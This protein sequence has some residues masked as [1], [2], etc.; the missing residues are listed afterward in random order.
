MAA[1]ANALRRGRA[2]DAVRWLLASGDQ[3]WIAAA[4]N[5]LL[6]SHMRRDDGALDA[7]TS[8]ASQIDAVLSAIGDAYVFSGA[9]EFV[10]NYARL[11]VM[12]RERT[13]AAFAARSIELLS[14]GAA[15][16]RYWLTLM[17]DCVPLLERMC[18]FDLRFAVC[19]FLTFFLFFST[20][21]KLFTLMC[22]R[23][24]T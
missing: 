14:D 8:R 9:L 5:A 2:G 17:L 3:R 12:W 18:L 22:R 6:E 20:Q 10:V 21:M 19:L 11:H 23:R 1:G 13:F 24:N 16:R 4:G 15:P 7:S